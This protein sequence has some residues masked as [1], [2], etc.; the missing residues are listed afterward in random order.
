MS[1]KPGLKSRTCRC[2]TGPQAPTRSSSCFYSGKGKRKGPGSSFRGGPSSGRA[3]DRGPCL[4]CRQGHATQKC[5]Q[6]RD[7]GV[8]E[9]S[10]FICQ[11]PPCSASMMMRGPPMGEPSR[12]CAWALACSMLGQRR[13]WL[14]SRP[15]SMPGTTASRSSTKTTSWR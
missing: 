5:V 13:P 12:L 8:D 6:K 1:M 15:W 14:Q 2:K 7:G 4:R 3:S 10:E 9:E 11:R